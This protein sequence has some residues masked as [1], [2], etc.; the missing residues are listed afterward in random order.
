M[1]IKAVLFDM[2]GVLVD[3]LDTWYH[4]FCTTLEHFGKSVI[5][6]EEFIRQAWSQGYEKVSERYFKDQRIEDVAGYYFSH[7]LDH[8]KY[9]APMNGACGVLEKLSQKKIRLAVISNTYSRLVNEVLQY[10]DI[11]GYFDVII[12]GDDVESGKPAPDMVFLACRR[13]DIKPDEAVVVGDTEYDMMAARAAG[14]MAVGYKT[15]GDVRIE[16]LTDLL[17]IVKQDYI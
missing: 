11:H 16:A 10:V 8:K 17:G 4:L 14:A 9:L 1:K 3:S 13:L 7:F 15:A 2:D 5:T 12:G 6:K